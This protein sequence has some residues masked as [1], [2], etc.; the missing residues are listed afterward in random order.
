MCVASG[1]YSLIKNLIFCLF[2]CI[3]YFLEAKIDNYSNQRN[4][5]WHCG[6][7]LFGSIIVVIMLTSEAK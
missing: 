1:N 2:V 5:G 3:V 6:L 4:Q 7:V